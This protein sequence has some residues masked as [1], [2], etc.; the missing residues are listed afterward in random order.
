MENQ[1]LNGLAIGQAG[2]SPRKRTRPRIG[3][4]GVGYVK[5]WAQ[6]EG[7]LDDLLRK[8]AV[9]ID[10]LE[11]A[12]AVDVIDFGLVDEAAK[13][14]ELVP[15]L[16]AA[17]LDLIFCDML[18][19]AT[20]STFGVI[21]RSVEVPI[22]L[23]ALQPDKA[24]DYSNASTY[25]QLYND[26]ICSLPEFTGVAVRMGK[27]VPEIIIGTLYDDPQA[28]AEIEEY[29]RIAAVL[30]DLKTARIG[31]I[32]HPIEAMLDMH[33]DSTMLTAH[34]GPHIVQCE[35]HEIVT[36][37][38]QATEDEI[39]AQKER[40]LAFFDTPDPVSDPISE[41]LRD[42]DLYVAARAAVALEQFIRTKKLDGLAYYYDGPENS[43]TRV[44]M[45]N[46]IVGNS[47]LQG[48]G[49]PMC[50]ESDLKT[51]IAMLIME[52]LGIGGSFA[53]FH[54]VD[55]KEDFVL[56]GHDGPH[57]IA[58]AEGQPVLRSLK[59]YHG[60]P[61]F[62]AGVEFKIKE[63]PITM[64]SINSTFDGKMKFIIA[65]G[66]SI[67]GPIPPTGNTNTRGF[68]KPDVRTFLKRWISEGP[69]HHFALGVG[70]HAATIR[71][72][73]DYLKV[74]SVIVSG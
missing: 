70:H 30:H 44:V 42:T 33:S 61:G 4:F 34:F 62:G 23:V 57:N 22:V 31:H 8:Q 66:E 21:I 60:K 24:M 12:D 47:L 53:E 35:A 55:F 1:L 9:F 7:L 67:A 3:V 49:F 16:N 69:T 5:Y 72:I 15:K 10:K 65:E 45:S 43:D 19:Y 25:L 28:D 36:H 74:E 20:S 59:K 17:N 64:L 54:P 50:G 63:G 26:D 6:F 11:K 46:L 27:K 73:A 41:K 29:C 32:G 38:L 51:C 58:I 14:Y 52:R 68:F 37:Y 13:A 48:A 56:V 2:I 39:D 18:T 71:K 40:I